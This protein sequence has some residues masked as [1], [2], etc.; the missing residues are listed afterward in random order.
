MAKVKYIS[1]YHFCAFSTDQDADYHV[2][3]NRG[4]SA[5]DTL[6]YKGVTPASMGRVENL[7]YSLEHAQPTFQSN[8]I[9]LQAY[10]K[11]T[12]DD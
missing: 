2:S 1:V 8:Y 3:F 4:K 5:G 12:N 9:H 7:F 6:R 11:E 10:T